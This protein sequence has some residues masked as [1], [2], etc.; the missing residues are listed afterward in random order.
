[1]QIDHNLFAAFA[2]VQSH[3]QQVGTNT[4][5]TYDAAD[6]ITLNNVSLANLQ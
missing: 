4:V 1:M 6:T 5:I 2:D 3:A